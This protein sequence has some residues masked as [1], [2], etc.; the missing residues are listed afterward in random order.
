MSGGKDTVSL[1]IFDL[2][3]CHEHSKSLSVSRDRSL[4]YSIIPL[5]LHVSP[6]MRIPLITGTTRK[7][8]RNFEE[9]AMTPLVSALSLPSM[10][11]ISNSF[12]S[13]STTLAASASLATPRPQLDPVTLPPLCRLLHDLPTHLRPSSCPWPTPCCQYLLETPS[14]T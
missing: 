14:P 6:L 4:L 9:T 13:P 1:S 2:E 3:S 10:P 7:Q 11:R 12:P 5:L 8:R